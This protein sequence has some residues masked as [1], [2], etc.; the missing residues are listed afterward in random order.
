MQS[1]SF[2]EDNPCYESFIDEIIM[3]GR[4]FTG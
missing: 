1:F 3:K 2:Q 4:D